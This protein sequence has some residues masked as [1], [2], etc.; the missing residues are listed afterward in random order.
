MEMKI[1]SYNVQ[2]FAEFYSQKVDYD[3]F[4]RTIEELGAD[5]VGLNETYG[6]GSNYS[7]LPQAEIL[8][9]KLGMD[10]YFAEAIYLPWGGVYGNSILSRFPLKNK[11]TVIIPDPE[12]R[13][14]DGYYETRC[15][16][17]CTAETDGG[18]LDVAVTHFGLN[19][20]EH[21]NAVK[22]ILPLIQEDRFILMGDFNV[23]PEDP[24]LDP[25]RE[26][27]TDTASAL[28]ENR[29]SFPSD[30][31]VKKIDYLF[32][33]KDLTVVSADIPPV[34]ASDHRPYLASLRF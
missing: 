20:D 5:I 12:P 14:Y 23:T 15:V 19:P 25:I 10:W 33:T 6:T 16:L 8:A 31:P 7:E 30:K 27:M 2:H 29:L 11:R 34:V 24:L 26:K 22:T 18:D 21:E 3:F 1:A 17:L 4:A 32:T 9:D 28:G 13:G